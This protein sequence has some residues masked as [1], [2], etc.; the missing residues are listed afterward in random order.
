[1]IDDLLSILLSVL[2]NNG[3]TFII[4]R[5][6]VSTEFDVSFAP[7]DPG[8]TVDNADSFKLTVTKREP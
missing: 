6:Q 4:S 5:G 7:A 3:E 1:M 8:Q 2:Y